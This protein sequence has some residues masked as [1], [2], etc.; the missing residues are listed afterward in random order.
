MMTQGRDQWHCQLQRIPIAIIGMA[1]LF[2][3]ARNLQEYWENIISRTDCITDVPPSCWNVEDYY[4]AD[5]KAP[6]KTYSRRGGFIPD[7]D[8]DPLE[9]GLPP[10][11]LEAIDSAQLLSLMVAQAALEDAGYEKLREFNRQKTGVVLGASGLWKMI[12][13][14]TSRL[15]YPIWKKVLKSSG[16]SDE[17]IDRI[18]EKIKLAY[19]P[20]QENSF[21]GMLT[22]VV[23]G[24]I[25]NRLDL[26]GTNCT[27]DAACASSLSALKMAVGELIEHRCDL[28]ITGGVDTDNSVLNY[29]C[30]SKT[31]AFSKKDYLSPFDADSDGM[32]VGEGLGM[33]VLKRLDDAERDG[34]RI[35]AVIK[36]IGTSSDGRY[37][38]IYAPRPEGQML[39]LRRAYEDAG[40]SP[41][42]VGLMEAH[43][44]GTPRGD[45]CEFTALNAV[46]GENNP[47]RQYIA[48]GSVK[49]QIG[50]TKAAAG[51]ASL[52]KVAL[53]LHH[54]VL[55]PTINVTKPNPNFN[56]KETPF[57]INTELRPW[58]QE[59]KLPRRA[60]V[61]SFGFG[62]TNFHVVLEEYNPIHSCAY[63]LH[64]APQS[65][66]LWEKTSEQLLTRCEAELA[67]LASP[68]AEHRYRELILDYKS[69][70]V[71]P[72]SARIG[73]VANS[74]AEA[75]ELLQVAIKLLSKQDQTESWEHPRGI[76]YRQQGLSLKGRVVALFPGQG[77][78][79]LNMGQA[80]AVNFPPVHQAYEAMN[81]LFV[82]DGLAPLS[83]VVF[84]RPILTGAEQAA[85]ALQSTENAQPAIG[86]FSVGL[87]KILQQAGFQP[88]FTAGH[89][90]GE[91]TALWAAQVLSDE[92]YFFL[93]KAR[94]EA[95]R[96]P[97]NFHA[98][99]AGTMLAVKGDV[100]GIKKIISGLSHLNI[101]NFN[102]PDQVVLSG[103]KPEI[104][105]VHQILSDQGYIL[106]P[107]PV[108]AAFHTAFVSHASEPFAKAIESVTFTPPKT[109]V[110]SNTSE[111]AY[112]N[113]PE[114]IQKLL[115]EH[116]IKPVHFDQEIENI[117]AQGGYCFVEIGP[118]RILTSFVQSI[119]GDRPHIA[120]ALNASREKDSDLQLRQAV[121]QLQ[122]A[123][124]PLK[125]IDFYQLA[126][127]PPKAPP[128][129]QLAI[130]LNGS[131]YVSKK[132]KE[133]FSAA[134]QDG[135]QVKSGDQTLSNSPHSALG[136]P[137]L[138]ENTAGGG[139]IGKELS[140]PMAE[141]QAR[142]ATLPHP[143]DAKPLPEVLSHP[144]AV[145]TLEATPNVTPV[146]FVD[147][148]ISEPEA[149]M[150]SIPQASTPQSVDS[151]LEKLLTQFCNHQSEVLRVHEQYL[152]NQA[153][154]SQAFFHIMHRIQQQG[155]LP[156]D[157]TVP[158]S[159]QV[160]PAVE[161]Q[162][163]PAE[164][165]MAESSV[166]VAVAPPEPRKQLHNG[167]EILTF[168]APEKVSAPIENGN[169]R[170]VTQV[171]QQ[172]VA[173][174][175]QELVTPIAFVIEPAAP[176]LA[177]ASKDS[178]IASALL[179]VVSDKTGYPAE[180]L[181]LEMDLEADL[182]IDSIKRV[183]IM[184]A[185]QEIIPGLPRLSTDD[186]NDLRTLG[187]IVS[188][189]AQQLAE[190][191]KKIA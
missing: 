159:L 44:T 61:S 30:F 41:A 59:D 62:G 124:L 21:P 142:P 135:Y 79:Y 107:V 122:V 94:G 92:D 89:S 166:A 126:P 167:A 43:G 35:Y 52:I 57:Y 6:D 148:F 102:T 144:A 190:A 26:G 15:Q 139:V 1:A 80:L 130:R 143:V 88:D 164:S 84:P 66:L 24:R 128:N 27:V 4:D 82:K 132:T 161:Q 5:P 184:G 99:D 140:S 110:Y 20:W 187:Q 2:P 125:D 150:H 180:M 91:L 9:F 97:Q 176:S 17:D 134:L 40:F 153:E 67:Q 175:V 116:L 145:Y 75:Q 131:N 38:S 165:L 54:K 129:K 138:E 113:E 149:M 104:A 188:Y 49:S 71:P 191:E 179:Q 60:G 78:Q 32:M 152:K 168:A 56:I 112:P 81:D 86:A 22:N 172:P 115:K 65:I 141:Q 185:V 42:T 3:K 114:A 98:C 111:Q 173:E 93:I 95:M 118:R 151:T 133:A 155:V 29:M 85:E 8:F 64:S 163:L 121:V 96:A 154:C 186:L 50:H 11:T 36:G 162:S 127:I 105:A 146:L 33:M 37:K 177:V 189:L 53:S 183:E 16:L 169:D 157:N 90:F 120:V 182:G 7:V 72:E 51:A 46:F 12:T 103:S 137:G 74:L 178:P 136:M 23:A 58:V 73:F 109:P 10:D 31:P 39:S 19:V 170:Q 171:R 108:S 181:E 68:T 70:E 147:D 100:A 106:T 119:L 14:L 13:P 48:L 76:Y 18:I 34:D 25:T 69:L 55:P 47:Q 158:Q 45:M 156:Q 28:M 123:G 63:R 83:Q 117:Y 174:V 160:I 87:Y 101:A 77:S